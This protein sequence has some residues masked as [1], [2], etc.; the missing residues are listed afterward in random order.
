MT[1][2]V[3]ATVDEVMTV[4]MMIEIVTEAGVDGMTVR[5]LF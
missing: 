1:M 4:T 2:I 5:L 3:V